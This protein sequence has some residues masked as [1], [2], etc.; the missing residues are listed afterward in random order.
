MLTLEQKDAIAFNT[1]LY[2]MFCIIGVWI[3]GITRGILLG[4]STHTQ[5]QTNKQTKQILLSISTEKPQL[6]IIGEEPK[7]EVRPNES[8]ISFED[9][10]K[11][12]HSALLLS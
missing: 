3:N 7:S 1:V 11:F 12:A 10:A 4:K 2:I 9:T 8:G 6:T 5:K